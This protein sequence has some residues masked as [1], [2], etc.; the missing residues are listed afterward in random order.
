MQTAAG[1]VREEFCGIAVRGHIIATIRAE[2]EHA[3][4]AGRRGRTA[5]IPALCRRV[6]NLRH[7]LK[8]AKLRSACGFD[9]SAMLPFVLQAKLLA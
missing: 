6:T 9:V 4:A 3:K 2:R 1:P 5:P 8:V 7:L